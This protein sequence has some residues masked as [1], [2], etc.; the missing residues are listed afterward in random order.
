MVFRAEVNARRMSVTNKI[1]TDL[2]FL[3]WGFNA[4]IFS[5]AMQMKN[6]M[7]LTLKL[8]NSEFVQS[9]MKVLQKH[10]V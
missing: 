9:N 8:L 2:H 5:K 1:T 10:D 6:K 7:F 4:F 3:R